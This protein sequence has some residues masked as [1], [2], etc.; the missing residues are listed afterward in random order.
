MPKNWVDLFILLAEAGVLIF[1]AVDVFRSVRLISKVKR[2]R[3]EKGPGRKK[4][5]ARRLRLKLFRLQRLKFGRNQL[6]ETKSGEISRT[7]DQEQ[8]VIMMSE[9]QDQAGS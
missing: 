9:L 8:G 7:G 1:L 3:T 2:W 6:N 4:P 5:L